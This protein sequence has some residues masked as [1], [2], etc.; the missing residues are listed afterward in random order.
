MAAQLALDQTFF[1]ELLEKL[2][3][4]TYHLQ[5]RCADPHCTWQ[6][7]KCLLKSKNDRGRPPDFIPQEDKAGRHV[8]SALEPYRV[9]N[10]G[11]LRIKHIHYTEHRTA[12][13]LLLAH[14]GPAALNTISPSVCACACV[15]VCVLVCACV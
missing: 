5:N 8:L 9:E 14:L 2:I 11:V 6:I 1:V 3:G 12:P 15:R 13:S 4:E 7:F 10:G